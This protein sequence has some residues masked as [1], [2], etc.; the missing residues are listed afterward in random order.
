M[1]VRLP[2]KLNKTFNVLGIPRSGQHAIVTWL[3][4]NLPSPSLFVN[5]ATSI[6]PDLVWWKNGRRVQTQ[7]EENPCVLGIGFEGPARVL[8]HDGDLSVFVIRDIKNHMASLIK[9]KTLN[10]NW[11]QFFQQW[12]EYANLEINRPRKSYPYIVVPFST[13][14]TC[15]EVRL[16][17]FEQFEY[18]MEIDGLT[19]N[20]DARRDIMGSGG[21]SSFT[22]NSFNGCAEKMKV[23]DRYKEVTLP[24]IPLKLLE[25]NTEIFGDI[26]S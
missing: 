3:M 14:H 16:D 7:I 4:G 10:P 21:G 22:G 6:R 25:M 15:L 20:D 11:P 13:W 9:H 26:Y 2:S 24:E 23:L 12:E 1:F 17:L 5:N 18:R 19:Y 8:D